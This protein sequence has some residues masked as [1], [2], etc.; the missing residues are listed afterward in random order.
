MPV[1]WWTVLPWIRRASS[2]KAVAL[3][4]KWCRRCVCWHWCPWTGSRRLQ[5]VKKNVRSGRK[6]DN[7]C[8]CAEGR[9]MSVNLVPFL[10]L[11]VSQHSCQWRP[12]QPGLE[13][14]ARNRGSVD[15]A[16]LPDPHSEM[17]IE[18]LVVNSQFRL[19]SAGH[20]F[21][22]NS[23]SLDHIGSNI[24]AQNM[25]IGLDLVNNCAS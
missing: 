23:R 11:F 15:W 9:S 20:L 7:R 13:T 19:E 16:I 3:C 25:E 6:C 12:W 5:N 24:A 21:D 8:A 14:K 4:P 17:V 10:R 18:F 22:C 2:G 1:L